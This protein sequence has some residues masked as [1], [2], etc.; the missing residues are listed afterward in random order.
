MTLKLCQLL[1]YKQGIFLWENHAEN[2]HQ[3]IPDS[4]LILVTIS[5]QSLHSKNYFKNKICRKNI[6]KMM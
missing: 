3:L 6:I 2:V 1:E 4:F 5:K